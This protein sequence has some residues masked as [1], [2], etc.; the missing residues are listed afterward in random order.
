MTGTNSWMAEAACQ[1]RTDLDWF[2]VD[3]NLQACLTICMTCPVADECYQYAL[4]LEV[5][6]GIWGGAWGVHLATSAVLRRRR[7][8]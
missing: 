4:E 3:C 5:D 1:G 2:D 7:G 8:G 6:E